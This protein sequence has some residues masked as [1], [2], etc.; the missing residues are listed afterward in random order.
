MKTLVYEINVDTRAALH[1]LIF[2]TAKH[3]RNH[4][5]NVASATHSLL[6]RAEN[7]FA[8]GGG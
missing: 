6:I 5:Y 2:S 7:I 1:E 4:P 3:I 8:T